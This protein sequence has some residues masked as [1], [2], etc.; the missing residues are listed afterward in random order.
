M[1]FFS[2]RRKNS[3]LYAH[4]GSMDAAP[5]EPH[6]RPTRR[7]AVMCEGHRCPHIGVATGRVLP[8]VFFF[9]FFTTCA[10]AAQTRADSSWIGL[11]HV[12]SGHIERNRRHHRNGR[13]RPKSCS[14]SH[15]QGRFTLVVALSHSITRLSVLFAV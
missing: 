9:F 6:L 11:I 2:K 5:E 7:N 15:L 1:Y 13:F 10:D 3:S 14:L 4:L 8:C 12:D